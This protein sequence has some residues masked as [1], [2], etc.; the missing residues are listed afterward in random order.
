MSGKGPGD[1]SEGRLAVYLGAE[2]TLAS[3]AMAGDKSDLKID[4][5]PIKF[6]AECKST[7]NES[8]SIKKFWLDKIVEESR[9]T[10]RWPL[11]ILSFTD[12]RGMAKRNGDWIAMRKEDWQELVERLSEAEE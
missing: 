10:N 12:G 4:L 11:L 6:R 1:V 7:V 9:T 5:Y 3:G 8:I 2:Q